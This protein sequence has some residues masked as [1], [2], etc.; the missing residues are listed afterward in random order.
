MVFLL[1]QVDSDFEISK[2]KF[3][4]TFFAGRKHLLENKN[5]LRKLVLIRDVIHGIDIQ[6]IAVEISKL[7]CFLT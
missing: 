3:G 2:K 1:E 7:R 5:Y 4:K 6:P